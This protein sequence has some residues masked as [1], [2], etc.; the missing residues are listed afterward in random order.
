MVWCVNKPG[1]LRIQELSDNFYVCGPFF[2]ERGVGGTLE[3]VV[4][5]VRNAIEEGLDDIIFRNIVFT[6]V[7]HQGRD[8]DLGES[9]NY[10]PFLERAGPARF[11]NF[12]SVCVSM[13]THQ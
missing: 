10:G 13:E 9:M 6:T 1:S 5:D 7:G 12:F 8:L 11:S 4:L 3:F 2:Q